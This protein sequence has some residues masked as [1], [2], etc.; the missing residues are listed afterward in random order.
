MSSLWDKLANTTAHLSMTEYGAYRLLLDH[1]IS[2]GGALQANEK[3]LLRV[4]RAIAKQEL[5]SAR[6]VLLEFFVQRDGAWHHVDADA[7][8]ERRRHVSQ[9]RAEIGRKGGS[10]SKAIAT[11]AKAKQL[12]PLSSSSLRK[13]KEARGRA[14]TG[15]PPAPPAAPTE[16]GPGWEAGYPLWAKVRAQFHE[17]HRSDHLWQMWFATCRPNGSPTVLI[18]ASRFERDQLEVRFGDQLERLFGEP[19]TFKFEP[20]PKAP[21]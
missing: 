4:C 21:Q 1:Y 16:N 12:L 7:L 18:C 5:D 10:K 13:K 9:I 20:Q 15:E 19:I 14:G 3:Q 6:S 2:M 8:I 17:L 11:Q